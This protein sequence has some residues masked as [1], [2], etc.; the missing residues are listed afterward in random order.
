M[1]LKH[2]IIFILIGFSV[3]TPWTL[4]NEFNLLSL[5]SIM[6]LSGLVCCIGVLSITYWDKSIKELFNLFKKSFK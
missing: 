3:A 4:K 5:L 2:I 6:S 1:K